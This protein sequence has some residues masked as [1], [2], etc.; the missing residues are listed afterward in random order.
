LN[1]SQHSIV[2]LAHA[3][4]AS[5]DACRAI[6]PPSDGDPTLDMA[7]GYHVLARI[8]ELRRQRGERMVGRKVGFTNRNIWRQYGVDSPCWAPV[9]DTTLVQHG[10][11]KLELPLAGTFSP[12]IEPEIAFGLKA[13]IG[14]DE[15][16]PERILEA[17]EWVAPAFE[18]VDCRYPDWKFRV[19]DTVVQQ[20]LHGALI[21]GSRMP[22]EAAAIARWARQL[23]DCRATLSCN[24]ALADSGIGANALGHPALALAFLADVL[25]GQPR[26]EPLAAGELVT[27]GTLTAALPIAAGETWRY[28]LEGIDLAPLEVRFI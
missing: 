20:G 26:F 15:R 12:R 17:I 2:A 3:E 11:E 5:Y 22:L 16:V 28:E 8:L 18:I 21:L 9:Y 1:T 6:V 24:G 7:K 14:A 4:L 19:E 27:T 10:G 23:H 13:G 25:A